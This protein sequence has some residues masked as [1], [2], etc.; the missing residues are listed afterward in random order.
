[1]ILHFLS[2]LENTDPIEFGN[3]V[4]LV[5]VPGLFGSTTNWRSFARRYSVTRPVI[6]IDQRNH[7][8][9]PH[10]DSHSYANMVQDLL[11]FCD[12][13]KF[14]IID[15]CGHSMGG[16]VAMLFTL[17]HPQRVNKLVVL[18][19]APIDYQHNH[20][21]F[22][23]KLM[24]LDLLQ[25][26]SR[27]QAD[28]LLRAAIPDTATRLFLLQNL[29]GSPGDYRWNLNLSV[30]HDYMA[31][32]T[33]FPETDHVALNDALFVAGEL[34]DYL[35][36]EHHDKIGQIFPNAVFTTV[37]EAGHWLHAQQTDKV[38]ETLIDFIQNDK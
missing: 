36:A 34:S 7:G 22:L 3:P 5:I 24:Q 12:Q 10:A 30:L 20:A 9:S 2:Y 14:L 18:D 35:L 17:T 25:L 21:P 1:M 37:A 32:I 6:V 28:L 23:K 33:G 29:R 13:H 4:P 26:K 19:I 38:L 16:K 31:E 27:N 15:L 11:D 8:H